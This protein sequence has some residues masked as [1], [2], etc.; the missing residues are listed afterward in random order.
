MFEGLN[1]DYVNL[2]K[3]TK[4][5]NFI[6]SMLQEKGFAGHC[7]DTVPTMENTFLGLVGLGLN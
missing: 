5:V 6:L 3:A 2:T 4:V 7:K 1:I